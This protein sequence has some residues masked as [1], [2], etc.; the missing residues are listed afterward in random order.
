MWLI[1][2]IEHGARQN[3][4]MLAC[5]CV[6]MCMCVRVLVCFAKVNFVN[7]ANLLCKSL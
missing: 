7:K 1:G 2:I 3:S 6:Y 5:V 4:F